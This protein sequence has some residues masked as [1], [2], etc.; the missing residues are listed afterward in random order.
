MIALIR[1]EIRA[2]F[3]SF[4]GYIVVGAFLLM[5]GL[6]LWVFPGDWNILDGSEASLS[7]LFAWA[8][9]IF[10]GLIPAIVMRSFAEEEQ[11]GTMELLL[12]R[13]LSDL[14]II[15]A[16]FIGALFVLLMSM[17]PTLAFLWVIGSLG[18]PAW[19]VDLG[20]VWGSYLGLFLLGS[21]MTALGLLA[22]ALTRNSLSAFLAASLA[23]VVGYIGFTAMSNFGLM[24]GWDYAFAQ[25]GME[26]HYR[27]M[28]DGAI[29]SRDLAYFILFDVLALF[30]TK[31]ALRAGR[32]NP[33][34]EA[35]QFFL[36][37][38]VALV[39]YTGIC[40]L[41]THWDWTAEKRHSLTEAT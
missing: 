8:P 25:L 6:F 12:T 21:S 30:A 37:A 24:G 41:P 32:G 33:R 22:S 9:W 29:D 38:A 5:T 14:S 13:P 7:P 10:M 39:L 35:V 26:A 40:A 17:L 23:S 20:A 36:R 3:G 18:K 28:V 15:W 16:K 19:N 11:S 4:T 31:W 27:G 34:Q 2:F 1:K